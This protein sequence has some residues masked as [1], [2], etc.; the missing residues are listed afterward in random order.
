M[1]R[2]ASR[3]GHT[4][5]QGIR[6]A[7]RRFRRDQSGAT[8]MIFAL[9]FMALFGSIG[10]AVEYSRAVQMRESVQTILD[11][12]VLAGANPNA[13][14]VVAVSKKKGKVTTKEVTREEVATYF[15]ESNLIDLPTA[16][17][18][19][20]FKLDTG[21]NTISGEVTVA[22]PLTLGKI[23]KDS[24]EIQVTSKAA[25]TSAQVRALDIVMCIDSTGSMQN[26]LSAVQTNAL[27]F[28]ANMDAALATL[29]GPSFDLMRTKVIYYKD[30]GGNAGKSGAAAGDAQPLNPSSFYELPKDNTPFTAFVTG[31]KASGGGDLPESGLECLNAAMKSSWTKIGDSTSGGKKITMVYPIVAIFTDAAAHLPGHALSLQNPLYPSASDMPRTAAD[32]LANWNNAS[33]IDQSN[34]QVLFYGDPTIDGDKSGWYAVKSWKGYSNPGSLTSANTSFVSSLAAGIVAGANMPMLTQ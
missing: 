2:Y 18:T 28:K 4:P 25:L 19:K 32:M 16:S 29:K 30:Y 21:A 8:A 12:A 17:I 27:N 5:I 22:M 34:K 15:F 24:L 3:K 31:Q 33:I 6:A 14:L 13:E 7:L 23:W 9:C 10:M 20:S 11:G 1:A 26:T